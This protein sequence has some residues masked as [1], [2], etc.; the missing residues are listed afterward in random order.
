MRRKL[1][2]SQP[3]SP[4]KLRADI[5]EYDIALRYPL[6]PERDG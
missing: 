1:R 2:W 5:S 6:M 3:P 4:G